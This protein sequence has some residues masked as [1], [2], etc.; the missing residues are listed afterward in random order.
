M[1]SNLPKNLLKNIKECAR[2]LDK[3]AHVSRIR[4]SLR[5]IGGIYRFISREL[6]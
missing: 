2:T 6:V 3:I 5:E 1:A 4:I